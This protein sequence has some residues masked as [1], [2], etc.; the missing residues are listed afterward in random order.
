MRLLALAAL[1]ALVL[2]SGCLDGGD[3]DGAATG[4]RDA[5]P[6]GNAT[7]PADLVFT[8]Q[9]KGVGYQQVADPGVLG[10]CGVQDS[11]CAVHQVTVPAGTWNVTFTLHGAMGMV[12][13]TVPGGLPINGQTDYDLFV[14]GVGESTNPSGQDDVVQATLPG[15]DYSAQVLAWN[16]V[17]G[18]YTLTVHFA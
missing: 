18:S 16:D 17:D 2:T 8:G 11:A 5:T 4:D 14:E 1:A 7:A 3:A 10:A 13:G 15:G 12:T 6:A 9:L